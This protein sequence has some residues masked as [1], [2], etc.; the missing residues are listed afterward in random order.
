MPKLI[1]RRLV[2]GGLVSSAG[3]LTTGCKYADMAPTFGALFKAGD[4]ASYHAQSFLVSQQSMAREFSAADRTPDFP[5]VGTK[6]PKDG[7]YRRQ[8]A[9]SFQ[10][11]RLPVTGS[12][13]ARDRFRSLN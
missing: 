11:W 3:L 5:V 13:S 10:D 7:E 6:L 1:G 9:Q 4:L 2:I 12:S 8:M